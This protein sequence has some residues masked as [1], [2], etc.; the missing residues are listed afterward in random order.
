MKKEEEEKKAREAEIE[1]L[2]LP[3]VI[4]ARDYMFLLREKQE[5]KRPYFCTTSSPQIA[6]SIRSTTS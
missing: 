6:Y 4:D 5:A 3:F 2:H 1:A